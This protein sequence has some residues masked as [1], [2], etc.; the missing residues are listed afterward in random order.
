MSW[1]LPTLNR[2]TGMIEPVMDGAALIS[3]VELEARELA[4]A[5]KCCQSIDLADH[6]LSFERA[7][8]STGRVLAELALGVAT[9]IWPDD[10]R[11]PVRGSMIAT[12]DENILERRC[13]RDFG[14]CLAA[15]SSVELAVWC[16]SSELAEC[17]EVEV[18]VGVSVAVEPVNVEVRVHFDVLP[19]SWTKE[20]IFLV[21]TS[22]AVELSK[23]RRH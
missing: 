2:A 8:R 4:V 3:S 5:S 23:S 19:A 20:R 15:W 17:T 7:D 9:D 21:R 10:E 12:A 6:C 14:C 11:D 18:L 22:Q 16:A 1:N 13:E